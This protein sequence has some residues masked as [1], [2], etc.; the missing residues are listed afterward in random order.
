LGIL[1]DAFGGPRPQGI[2]PGHN[3]DLDERV[4]AHGAAGAAVNGANLRDPRSE[5]EG[6]PNE[7][8]DHR[9]L[10]RERYDP[11]EVD[12]SHGRHRGEAAAFGVG[13][14]QD[15][16]AQKR[17]QY[18]QIIKEQA[19]LPRPYPQVAAHEI[20]GLVT[21]L[22]ESGA[23]ARAGLGGIVEK[24]ADAYRKT[25]DWG[26]ALTAAG[27]GW[28]E[29]RDAL[30]NT[31][32]DQVQGYGLTDVQMA[33]FRAASESFLPAGVHDLLDTDTSRATE[34]ARE[35]LI[36][37]E[38]PTG[39]HIAELL[40]RSAISQDD[41]YLRTIGAYNRANTGT[42]PVSPPLSQGSVSGGWSGALLDLIA[43]PESRGNYNAWYGD[44]AQ[45]R[46]DLS[47]FTVDQVRD[48]QADLVRSN[49]GSA[50]G[51]YQFLDDT[52]DGLVDRLGLNGNER[53]S[54]EL[55]DRLALQL[56]RDAGMED[57]IGGRISDER[58]AESLSQVWAGLPRDESNES[59]Y[60]GIQGNRAT[61][62][63]NTVIAALRG[64]RAGRP[65]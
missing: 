58:F 49:G 28:Q 12:R 24:L 4:P 48:L 65:S 41:T 39:E 61:V 56:A 47:R 40:T 63:W 21:G 10:T 8:A 45:D 18:A 1:A 17:E 43:A 36:R 53:F 20:G 42:T 50:V 34:Q 44:A 33:F 5:T 6:L 55:Q 25:G 31:R 16:R 35:A 32:M 57:W 37:A 22:L 59:Y 29:A 62:D 30:I 52:L 13:A 9:R 38:G 15:M 11:T 26:E 14:S 19:T 7:V 27:S 54:P 60:E 2:S 3:A 51:R 46:V 23:L 64:I